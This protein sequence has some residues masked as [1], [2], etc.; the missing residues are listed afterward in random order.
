MARDF[1]VLVTSPTS[2]QDVQEA[3]GD[4]RYWRDRFG[5]LGVPATL[6]ELTVDTDGAITVRT[7]QDLRAAG[8]PTLVT[9]VYPRDLLVLS[10]ER[11]TPDGHGRVRGEVSV[12]VAGAPG[13]GR[14]R[15]VL[16]PNEC[17]SQMSFSGTVEF[18]VPLV[19][20]RVEGYL[21]AQLCEHIPEIQRFTTSWILG[22]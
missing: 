18:R 22:R 16:E 13:S 19:G 6:S 4:E 10:M 12:D 14:G 5:A 8:L 11:W 2:V 3:F 9:K 15:A 1:H 21:G 7:V 20:R 17:G